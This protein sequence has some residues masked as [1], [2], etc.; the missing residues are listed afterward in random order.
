[1]RG[2][3]IYHTEEVHSPNTF[4]QG[5]YHVP[6]IALVYGATGMDSADRSWPHTAHE[7]AS[8]VLR[9]CSME[10]IVSSSDQAGIEMRLPPRWSSAA[11]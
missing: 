10:M 2:T 1:M 3:Y 9:C 11:P 5:T 4:L 6:G 8:I 7:L